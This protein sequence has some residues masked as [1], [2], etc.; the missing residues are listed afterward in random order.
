MPG[1]YKQ[2]DLTSKAVIDG[3]LYSG[4]LGYVDGDGFL[5]LVDRKKDMIISGGINVY[6]KDI[7]EIIA[8]HKAVREVAVFGIPHEKWGETPVAAIILHQQGSISEKE[9]KD[10]I[11][12]SVGATYQRVDKVVFMDDFPRS[13]AG[14]TLKRVMR[15]ELQGISRKA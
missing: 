12:Q 14:K 15:D 7:E 2:P 4:D 11:N 13:S 5:Y 1:Y 3:W 10:W 6:P 9:L 8:R